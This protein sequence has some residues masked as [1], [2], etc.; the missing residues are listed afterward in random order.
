[1]FWLNKLAILDVRWQI[2]A[3]FQNV[4]FMF[5]VYL[6]SQGTKKSS[7]HEREENFLRHLKRCYIFPK[8][9]FR[10]GG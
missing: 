10:E 7:E 8:T 9:L 1:M 2:T 4:K 5:R 6:G 3:R